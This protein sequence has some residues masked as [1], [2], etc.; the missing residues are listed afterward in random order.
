MFELSAETALSSPARPGQL[1]PDPHDVKLG[2]LA[3]VKHQVT[4]IHSDVF[5]LGKTTRIRVKHETLLLADRGILLVVFACLTGALQT[6][7]ETRI[8][9]T[10]AGATWLSRVVLWNSVGARSNVGDHQVQVQLTSPTDE[11]RRVGHKLLPT[12]PFKKRRCFCD[13]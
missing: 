6:G 11:A 5:Q 13:S 2:S 7:L 3:C 8:R 4:I 9:L 1:F 10:S 12:R